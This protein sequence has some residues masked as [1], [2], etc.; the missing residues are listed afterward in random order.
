MQP[1]VVKDGDF[2]LQLAFQ[3]GFDAD[4]VWNDPSNDD[5]RSIRAD[6]NILLA[7]DLL[8]VPDP[9]DPSSQATNLTPG[10]T[11]NFVAADPPTF[12][13][14]H[15][16]VGDDTTS[17]ASQAYTVQELAQLT[18]LQTDENGTATFQAPVTL[19]TATIVFTDSGESFTLAMGG[20]D[21][22]NT[23]SG[24]FKRL[25][26]LGYID[27]DVAYDADDPLNNLGVMSLALQA[28]KP[29]SDSPPY[30]PPPPDPS[31]ASTPVPSSPGSTPPPSAPPSSTPPS[32]DDSGSNPGGSWCCWNHVPDDGKADTSG[33]AADGTLDDETTALLRS[34]YGC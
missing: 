29:S 20:M 15:T 12:A 8:H 3:M 7:G 34:A 26:N 23:I 2:L 4:T 10:S 11:N 5:L 16:F 18:G 22:I 27:D 25:Q 32:G 6:P 19:Q 1:Y 9:P 24:I 14:T 17:Y 21:P 31:P 28:L 33:L 13:L 30:V